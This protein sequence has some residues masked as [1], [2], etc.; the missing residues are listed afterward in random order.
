MHLT[1]RP[2]GPADAQTIAAIHAAAWEGS[3]RG[4]MPDEEFDRRPLP[5]RER[6]WR[7]WLAE[8]Y[9]IV[10][11]A[12]DE[13][14]TALGFAGGWLMEK[15]TGFDSYLATLYLQPN[16]KRK[17]VGK[18]LLRAFARELQSRGARSMMLRT[19]RRN[20]QARAFYEGMGARFVAEGSDVEAG[21][22]DD[23][24]YAFDD[25]QALR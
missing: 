22:F 4:I 15:S 6:Q 9:R 12:T 24:V 20:D 23:V 16:V 13:L 19:L 18:A 3:Y 8:P 2:A 21:L 11:V 14:Q 7:E 1:I 25:L 10:L 17:G 5:V